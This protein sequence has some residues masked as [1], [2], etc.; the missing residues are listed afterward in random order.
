MIYLYNIIDKIETINR[1][2]IHWRLSSSIATM[3][4]AGNDKFKVC[5]CDKMSYGCYAFLY[6]G[7]GTNVDIYAI[8]LF[9]Y[10]CIH[11]N[12]SHFCMH[13]H[14]DW[15]VRNLH[16]KFL[17]QAN[18][19]VYK[20]DL[21]RINKSRFLIYLFFFCEIYYLNKYCNI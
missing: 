2:I 4:M 14:K 7:R 20:S 18:Y 13:L 1:R 8:D 21:K 12:L 5:S 3:R 15:Y 17:S 19:V 16:N 10:Y 6:A 9:L 11:T